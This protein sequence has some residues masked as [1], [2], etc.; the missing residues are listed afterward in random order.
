MVVKRKNKVNAT[1]EMMKGIIIKNPTIEIKIKMVIIFKEEEETEMKST[2]GKDQPS[3]IRTEDLKKTKIHGILKVNTSHKANVLDRIREIQACAGEA[4]ETEEMTREV[5]EETEGMMIEEAE[6]EVEVD[7][8][9]PSEKEHM[10][11]VSK[12]IQKKVKK[13]VST[14]LNLQILMPMLMNILIMMKTKKVRIV[15]DLE[16]EDTIQIVKE[17]ENVE[18]KV[19]DKADAVEVVVVEVMEEAAVVA[20]EEEIQQE[21][22]II[23]ETKLLERQACDLMNC[24][25]DQKKFKIKK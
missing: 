7:K 14:L 17:V 9:N 18:D 11:T 19:K 23:K 10:A 16:E 1:I 21:I 15:E 4:E 24:K 13:I 22:H 5:A 8:N 12:G 20:E 3:K 25:F 6:E 2:M